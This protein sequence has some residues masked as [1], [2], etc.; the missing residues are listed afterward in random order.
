MTPELKD[1]I[2]KVLAEVAPDADLKNL[3]PDRLFRDQFD[4]DSVDCL[5]FTMGLQREL[6]LTISE[7]DY[8][9]CSSLN[10]CMKYLEE[11]LRARER[12]Q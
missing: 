7:T 12:S 10:G 4:F 8:P 5:N 9:R 6:K 11:R 2:L 1:T 3:N